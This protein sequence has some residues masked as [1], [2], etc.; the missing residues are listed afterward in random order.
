MLGPDKYT[1]LGLRQMSGKKGGKGI[2]EVDVMER[3]ERRRD[4]GA[5]THM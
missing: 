1:L 2:G 3:R 5:L 4:R